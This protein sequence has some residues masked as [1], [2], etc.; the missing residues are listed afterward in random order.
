MST[1]PK[2]VEV[3]HTVPVTDLETLRVYLVSEL[4]DA[5]GTALDLILGAGFIVKMVK[6]R[7]KR[8]VKP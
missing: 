6:A 7:K 2:Q 8:A 3:T 1:S 4:E 5:G